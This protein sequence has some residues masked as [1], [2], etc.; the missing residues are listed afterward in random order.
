M[1]KTK[2]MDNWGVNTKLAHGG[3][4]PHD[5]HGF[6]N[7]PVVRA[8]TV[9]FPDANTMAL[10]NQAYTYGTHGT[11]TT[12]ALCHAVDLLEGS[13]VT[14]L[15]PSGLAA[16]TMPLLGALS[17]GDHLLITDSVYFP[18]RRFADTIL[19]RMG[20]EVEYYDPLIG[21][22]IEKLFKDNT[23]I[24]FTESPASNTFEMQDIPAIA[25]AAHKIGAIVM[26]DNTWATPLL[27]K[28]LDYGVDISINAAT[29][30][31]AGHADVLMGMVSAN[32]KYAELIKDAHKI[33]G[34]SVSGDD[35]YLVLRSMRTM[36]IR[37]AHQS[38]TTIALAS[39]LE[40]LP[41]V[42]EVLHPEL[43]SNKGHAIWCRDFKGSAT[44]FSI[45]LKNGGIEEASRFLDSLQLFGLG[46]SWGGYE[47][48]AV[49]VN[50]KD[51]VVAKKDYA[52]PVLRLQI[53]IENFED[54]QKDLQNAINATGL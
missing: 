37:L 46:Y 3:Y 39:W 9:L 2:D 27:F 25:A 22:G 13:A 35:A 31:P 6:V 5:Y 33:T 49:H 29:K 12:D 23:R 43:P 20:V 42:A 45:V 24:V 21:A 30:Y 36:N 28:A 4:N 1:A 26:M 41:Q 18:T 17:S 7:P 34:M 15:T 14:V 52:G 19:T 51:R 40:T 50:L 10:E 47:S 32:Q 44:I 16:I 48:L 11:T 54:L 53:G 8:S 38:K